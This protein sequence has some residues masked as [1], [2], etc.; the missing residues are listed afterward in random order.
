MDALGEHSMALPSLINPTQAQQDLPLAGASFF[1]ESV[2]SMVDISLESRGDHTA[3]HLFSKN[4][5]VYKAIMFM[6]ASGTGQLKISQVLKVSVHTVRAVIQ[7]ENLTRGAAMDTAKTLQAMSDL[8]EMTIETLMEKLAD[9]KERAKIPFDKLMIGLGIQTE[10]IELLRGNATERI[11]YR[12][13]TPAADEFERWLNN[14]AIDVESNETGLSGEDCGTKGDRGAG[15]ALG[16]VPA[17]PAPTAPDPDASVPAQVPGVMPGEPLRNDVPNIDNVGFNAGKTNDST[18]SKT[19]DVSP[20]VSLT[21]IDGGLSG[22]ATDPDECDGARPGATPA[23]VCGRETGGE[24]V[25]IPAPPQQ[26]GMN[27]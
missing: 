1:S 17:T 27:E 21:G 14:G 7:R 10:K 20:D 3:A 26:G 12:D 24:G 11:E 22:A 4:Q 23:R 9:P 6:Y 25:T 2:E 18:V 13:T 15:L 16:P 8:R 5:Q 19:D